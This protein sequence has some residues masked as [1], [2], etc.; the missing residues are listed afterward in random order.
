MAAHPGCCYC[1]LP[2]ISS[3][4]HRYCGSCGG[5]L[6]RFAPPFVAR[7]APVFSLRRVPP[8]SAE[9]PMPLPGSKV[10]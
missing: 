2:R 7:P 1:A 10:G 6:L 4:T 8:G 9:P 5:A 3:A